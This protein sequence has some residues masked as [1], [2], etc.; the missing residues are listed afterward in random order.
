MN[1]KIIT[2]SGSYRFRDM[3]MEAYHELTKWG[4][5]VWLPDIP[6]KNAEE[7]TPH[8]ISAYFTH[9]EKIR[10]SD[11]LVVICPGNYIGESTHVEC[12]YAKACHVRI[13]Y[14]KTIDDLLEFYES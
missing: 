9:A 14:A 7:S 13:F 1:R 8:S 3:M 2:I 5:L 6:D 4:H 11:I 12:N 10:R